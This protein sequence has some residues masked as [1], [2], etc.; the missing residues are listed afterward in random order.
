VFGVN[1]P[2]TASI[3]NMPIEASCALATN[4][5]LPCGSTAN[6]SGSDTVATLGGVIGVH[7][8]LLEFTLYMVT[9]LLK[10]LDT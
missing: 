10:E 6:D 7:M 1:A 9:E 3:L 8:P 2:V 5:N 4:R